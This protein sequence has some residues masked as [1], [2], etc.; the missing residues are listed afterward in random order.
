MNGAGLGFGGPGVVIR[1]CVMQD[2]GQLGFGA[3]GA[4]ELLFTGCVVRNN[5][6]KGF[7]RGWEAGGDKICFSHGVVIEK[8]QFLDNRGCGIWFD[9]ANHD[10]TVR[11]C[12]IAN[13]EDAGIFYEISYG[14]HAYDNVVVG[15][16]FAETPG[17]W[18]AEAGICLSSSPN[19]V[20][21][22]NLLVANKEGFNFREQRRTTPN[23]KTPGKE[24][25]VWNHDQIIRNN[26]LAY[27]RDAQTWG[28]F[29]T[30]TQEW[31]RSVTVTAGSGSGRA[32]ADIA[33]KYIR[34]ESKD[35]PNL[36][37]EDLN[38][39]FSGNFYA[40]QDNEQIFHWG[41][42]WHRNK[43]YPTLD[44]VRKELHL[45]QGSMVGAF[46]FADLPTLD[47]RVPADSPALKMGCYPKGDV[48]GVK[49][50]ALK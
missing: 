39:R 9:I 38:L 14:L 37:L 48:P 49:L 32:G 42:S 5:N 24:V 29:D 4:D 44:A 2:N 22:R 31:P 46:A 28:W 40:V 26:T 13:N 6:V 3:G 12:L 21:E 34:E 10:C 18:G 27:N 17:S 11:N 20:I 1:R 7:D 30:D 8:S 23:E 43:S 41:V 35:Y 50:G 19:C 36:A 33:A 47:L 45:E 16:G 25:W 15:N